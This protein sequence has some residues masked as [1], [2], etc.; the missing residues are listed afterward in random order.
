MNSCKLSVSDLIKQRNNLENAEEI[1][2]NRHTLIQK[3]EALEKFILKMLD[4]MDK[5]LHRFHK[6]KKTNDRKTDD[7]ADHLLQCKIDE[8]KN[9]LRQL[10]QAQNKVDEELDQTEDLTEES[11]EQQRNELI[12]AMWELYPSRRNEQETKWRKMNALAL[13]D[14]ELKGVEELLQRLSEKL[15]TAIQARQSI[16]GRGILN[17]IFGTSPNIIIEKQLLGSHAL[18]QT[19]TP[20]LEKMIEQSREN[21]QLQRLFQEIYTWL[22]TLKAPCH[23]TWSFRHIDTIFAEAFQ[24]L[25][26]FRQQLEIERDQVVKQMN[27]IQEEVRG[28][29]HE[30]EQELE[31]ELEK[32]LEN[33]VDS[34]VE[35]E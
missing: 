28:W 12:F 4:E 20:L 23:S 31:P 24:T 29:L 1:L 16:K 15:G 11:L 5:D 14:I 35:N 19:T 33:G 30:L 22:E 18:I 9:A 8:K 6:D 26:G 25:E 3:R 17:Y 32:D 2:K 13:L 10:K 21:G 7:E 34:E 27:Q